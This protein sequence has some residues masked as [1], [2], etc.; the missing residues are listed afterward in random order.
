MLSNPIYL[1]FFENIVLETLSPF[2]AIGGLVLLLRSKKAKEYFWIGFLIGIFWFWW[3]GL[4][5]IYFNLT[6]L[7]PLI[8]LIMGLV[9]GVLFRICH[10]FKFDSLRLCAVFG[11]SFI[12]PL[13]FDW[14]NWGV[15]SVYG[16][17]DASTKGVVCI[18]LIAYFCYEKYIS[19]YYK[20]A[21]VLALF[22]IAFHYEEKK[23]A[24]LAL[25]FTLLNTNI[26]Q[27]QKYLVE[28]IQ[29]HSNELIKEILKAINEKK[30]LIV[31]PETAFAFD[32]EKDFKAKYEKILKQLS[33]RIVIITGAFSTKEDKIY[34]STYIFNQGEV[35][36]LNKHFLVPF[37]EELPLFKDLVRSY[38]LPN[39][40]EFSQ[41]PML[42]KYKLNDQT[43]T[44]AICYE[45]TKEQIYKGSELIIAISNN[46]WFDHSSEYKLQQLLMKFYANKYGVSVYHAVNGKENAIIKPKKLLYER[47]KVELE[48]FYQKITELLKIKA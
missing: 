34:N 26:P 15:F 33:H 28:N 9:Y 22:F 35:Y 43:V 18:F 10:L 5:S 48:N 23:A 17:F 4:S 7:V 24:D 37:G 11:L 3:V 47:W 21:I 2:L 42:S 19:R 46:A 13:G 12:H 29:N 30:E 44:N 41:G 40:Q 36:V 39:M 31:L 38:F 8:A 14:L 25:N 6:Y 27:N 1:S 32:L 20:I 16:F 45:A